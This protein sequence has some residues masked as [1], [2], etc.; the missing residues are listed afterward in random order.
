MFKLAINR[1]CYLYIFPEH[2][3]A[4]LMQTVK[5]TRVCFERFKFTLYYFVRKSRVNNALAR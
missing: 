1:E 2:Y 4:T 5:K 3:E